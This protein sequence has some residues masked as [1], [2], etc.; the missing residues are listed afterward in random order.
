[1]KFKFIFPF[2]LVLAALTV[3]PSLTRA[4]EGEPVV[5]DEV[6]A[7]VNDGVITLSQLKREMKERVETL[8]QSGMSQ[9]QAETEV[10]K[11]KADLI[12]ILIN[13]QLLLQKGKELDLTDRVEAEVNRRML[14]VAKQNG[15]HSIEE[16]DKA[17]RDAGVDPAGTRQTMRAEIMKQAVLE[18][19]VDSKLFYGANGD[20]LHRYFDAH[21]DKFLKPE[22]VELSEIFLSLAGKPEADVKARAM[23]LVQQIRGGANFTTLAKTNSERGAENG[24]KVGLF[25]ITNLRPDIA[26]AIKG[27]KAGGVAEPLRTDEGYDILRVDA[28]TVGSNTPTFNENQ[29]REAI[30]AERSPKA[31]EEYLQTLRDDAYVKVSKDYSDSVLPQLKLKQDLIVEKSG[32]DSAQ[33]PEKKKGRILGIF[34]KP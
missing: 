5:V 27:V 8:K 33:K 6:V 21:K 12:A 9:Q 26:A 31:R 24:G 11:H 16:L 3:S 18:S 30:T 25:E 28:R 29:V 13:E 15:V 22:S 14:E 7:Q 4:Q 10:E 2:L 1:M 32:D 34:P 23:Q 20:E 19:E 17:M